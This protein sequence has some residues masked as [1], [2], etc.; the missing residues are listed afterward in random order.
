MGNV[1]RKIVFPKKGLY[2]RNTE[3]GT[4]ME[5]FTSYNLQ[6]RNEHDDANDSLAMFSHEIIDN[7]AVPTKIQIIRR[8]F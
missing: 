5:S 4:F 6:G 2:G 8:P 7:G 1:K 3:M